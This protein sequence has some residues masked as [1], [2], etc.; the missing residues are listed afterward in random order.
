MYKLWQPTQRGDGRS[1]ALECNDKH[2]CSA[3]HKL[4]LKEFVFNG[5]QE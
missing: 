2:F 3:S 1:L 4:I 5:I